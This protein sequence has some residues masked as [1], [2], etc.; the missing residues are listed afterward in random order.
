MVNPNVVSKFIVA[1]TYWLHCSFV[2]PCKYE[3]STNVT[4]SK[5]CFYKSEKR[6]FPIFVK[7]GIAS[8]YPFGI[9][10]NL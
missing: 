2:A 5:P 6:D 7:I 10:R 3:S 1:L 4:D 8:E 9:P